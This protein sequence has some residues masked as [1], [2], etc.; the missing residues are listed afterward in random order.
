M[1]PHASVMTDTREDGALLAAARASAIDAVGELYR[2]HGD[3]VYG[4][5]Y[6]ILGSRDEAED[7]L[8]DVFVGL[9]RA[10][11]HYDERGRFVSWLKRVAVRTAL[12][13]LRRVRRRP[14]TPLEGQ[15]D[16]APAGVHPL[17]RVA[18]ER[19]IGRLPDAQRVVFILKEVEGYSHA[20][21]GDLIGIAAATSA[22]RL[23]RAW[24][25]LRKEM[26]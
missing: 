19:A 8:Q 12:M 25:A 22:M 20:E 16:I 2:R 15:I 17:D 4:V 6:R 5:A 14:V 23:S 11:A 18:L 9:S 26:R 1:R 7:V 10:L 21:I 3:M 13:H 24:A